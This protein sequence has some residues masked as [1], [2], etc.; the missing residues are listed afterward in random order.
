[1]NGIEKKKMS[2]HSYPFLEV[3]LVID[4]SNL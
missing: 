2:T 1:M 4:V 3:C